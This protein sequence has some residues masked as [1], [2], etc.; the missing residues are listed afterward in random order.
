MH[1]Y[2]VD[3]QK[4][5][6]TRVSKPLPRSVAPVVGEDEWK[7]KTLAH[8]RFWYVGWAEHMLGAV[9]KSRHRS[10]ENEND[11]DLMHKRKRHRT[12]SDIFITA[13]TS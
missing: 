11:L 9:P 2:T 5:A 3:K 1:I 12:S 6:I 7:K 8:V 4:Y 13:L 10:G